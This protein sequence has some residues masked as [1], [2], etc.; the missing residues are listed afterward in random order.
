M[1]VILVG[2]DTSSRG[3]TYT[4]NVTVI[5]RQYPCDGTGFIHTVNFRLNAQA[6]VSV[7]VFRQL[8]TGIWT[9]VSGQ[10]LG[11]YTSGVQSVT[12]LALACEEGDCL[13]IYCS[14]NALDYATTGGGGRSYEAG[15]FCNQGDIFSASFTANHCPS[16]GGSGT[17]D[18]PGSVEEDVADL[19]STI[20]DDYLPATRAWIIANVGSLNFW[21]YQ[22]ALFAYAA[23]NGGTGTGTCE[24]ATLAQVEE[25]IQGTE[26]DSVAG[27]FSTQTAAIIGLYDALVLEHEATRTAIGVTEGN[28]DAAVTAAHVI[29]DGK[30]DSIDA[31]DQAA[32][33]AAVSSVNSHTTGVGNNVNS[34]TDSKIASAISDINGNTDYEVGLARTAIAGLNNLSEAII[35]AIADAAIGTITGEIGEAQEAILAALAL[36]Q[37]EV[38]LPLYPGPDGVTFGT[39]S[40]FT[41]T[42]KI[43]TTMDGVVVEITA[44]SP[45]K[46]LLAAEGVTNVKYIG[47]IVFLASDGACD[48]IQW[49]GPTKRA[50]LPKQL[51][52]PASV[53]ICG[54]DGA[55]ITATPFTIDA[56]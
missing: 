41:N 25:L 38:Q 8:N 9:C 4:G 50:Y 55:E 11:L 12:D 52:S 23:L 1:T 33:D 15:N 10:T 47:W 6:T 7:G 36:L 40:S 46:G 14:A 42:E 31:L 19:L 44:W 26:E 2:Q 51:T 16:F 54:R 48:E 37:P 21:D 39:P 27:M 35:Q 3:S 5:E 18:V 56:S 29:T 20:R 49:L 28:L 17:V 53:V 22:L 43:T 45:E 34:N 24:G 32:L 13:G 30:I